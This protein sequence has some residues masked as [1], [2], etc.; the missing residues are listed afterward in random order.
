MSDSDDFLAHYGV[1]GMRWGKR[2]SRT[3]EQIAKTKSNLK[4]GAVIVGA[5]AVA[6]G[7]AFVAYKMNNSRVASTPVANISTTPAASAG[8]TA[9]E[10]MVA[11]DTTSKPVSNLNTGFDSAAAKKQMDQINQF[12]KDQQKVGQK[13][14]NQ[15]SGNSA[16]DNAMIGNIADM[17][18][19]AQ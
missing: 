3:P 13:I 2:K 6:A 8:K 16:Q 15:A 14:K 9:F 11:F 10:K 4:K 7:A 18:K 12:M 17:L 5:V 19:K 1:K